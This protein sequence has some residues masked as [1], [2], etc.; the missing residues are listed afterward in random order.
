MH[1]NEKYGDMGIRL[2]FELVI[3][4][5]IIIVTIYFFNSSLWVW[6]TV[7]EVMCFP[8]FVA[9]AAVQISCCRNTR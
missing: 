4:S 2:G 1:I 3:T 9:N 5:I 8:T 6:A 7:L